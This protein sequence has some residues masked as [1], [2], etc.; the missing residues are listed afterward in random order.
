M[1]KHFAFTLVELCVVTA[2]IAVLIA[3]LL[4]AVQA[5]RESAR[6]IKCWNNLKQIGIG[7]HNY[8]STYGTFTPGQIGC[9]EATAISQPDAP[10]YY[11]PPDASDPTKP[12]A[13][14]KQPDKSAS[15]VN[16]IG[17]EAGWALFL[18]PFIEQTG[19]YANYNSDLW[20]DHP[21]N[22]AAVQTPISTYLCPSKHVTDPLTHPFGTVPS[23]FRAARLHYVGVETSYIRL[24]DK[25]GNLDSRDRTS[26]NG[27]LCRI[28]TL[29]ATSKPYKE[30][31]EFR[32]IVP[33]SD[34]PDGFSNTMMVTEDCSFYDGAWCSGRNIFQLT[35]Y[36]FWTADLKA[37]NPLPP[38]RPLNDPKQNQNGFHAEHPNGL[39]FQFADG[40]VKFIPNEIDWFVVRCWVNRMDGD[41]FAA[42]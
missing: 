40:S 6:R 8:Y 41:V 23:D 35:E 15:T 37:K 33:V 42:P 19:I 36:H 5:A 17:K 25:D 20:I 24:P 14:P 39:N 11:V 16:D 10:R 29:R 9:R 34:V 13:T 31:I 4:P 38:R 2:I 26:V 32:N 22:R 21:D 28:R 30:K 18:L 3:I 1:K 7:Q 27:M 12:N